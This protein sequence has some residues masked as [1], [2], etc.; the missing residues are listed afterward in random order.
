MLGVEISKLAALLAHILFHFNADIS[1]GGETAGV[2]FEYLGDNC[3]L[4][5]ISES[6]FHEVEHV[7]VLRGF[8]FG[9]RFLL[10]SL[11][12]G[13]IVIYGFY[14]LAAVFIYN[15][16]YKLVHIIGAPEDLIAFI[17]NPLSLGKFCE[18]CAVFTRSIIDIFLVLSHAGLIVLKGGELA[19]F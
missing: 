18:I 9:G 2:G 7:F 15:L 13:F 10:I 8:L 6:L 17:K 4:D 16:H 5:F 12:Q 3:L 11:R 19:V 14:L 1:V